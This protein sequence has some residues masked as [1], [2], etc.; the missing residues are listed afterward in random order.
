MGDETGRGVDPDHL[1]GRGRLQN[2]RAERPGAAPDVQPPTARRHG[3]PLE[4]PTRHQATP[5]PDEGLVF[6]PTGPGLGR[7]RCAHDSPPS[8]RAP[9]TGYRRGLS[10]TRPTPDARPLPPYD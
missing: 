5:S 9:T 3:Q 1:R 4:K 8:R 6:P 7:P 10:A 2:D